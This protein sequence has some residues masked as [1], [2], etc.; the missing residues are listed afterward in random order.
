MTLYRGSSEISKVYRGSTEIGKIYKGSQLIFDK[1]GPSD[2]VAGL[3]ADYVMDVN[4]TSDSL[5]ANTYWTG[6]DFTFW[7]DVPQSTWAYYPG[8]TFFQWG[9]FNYG[10]Y[11]N[12]TIKTDFTLRITLRCGHSTYTKTIET[13][14]QYTTA[15]T[16]IVY[17]LSWT[18]NKWGIWVDGVLDSIGKPAMDVG[19]QLTDDR[20]SGWNLYS[21]DGSLYGTFYIANEKSPLL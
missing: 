4:N 1:T 20:Y 11:I 3:T 17:S 15:P 21:G 13:A 5:F 8:F 9:G 19:A 7:W 16:R 6:G 14:Q 2:P 10:D 18:Q 12:V